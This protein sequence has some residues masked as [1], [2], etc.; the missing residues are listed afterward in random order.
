MLEI[1]RVILFVKDMEAMLAF[2]EG[3]LGLKRMEAPDSSDGFVSLDAGGAQ[4]SL[5]QI[6]QRYAGNIEIADPPAPR[7]GT[8]VKVAF[9]VD[10]LSEFRKALVSHGVRV[11]EIQKSDSGQYCDGVDP[12][13]NIFQ[14]YSRL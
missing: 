8:P 6:P 1:A 9:R 13:G 5:H 11:F 3:V 12:E 2:Y 10:K 4:L 14:V 7:E